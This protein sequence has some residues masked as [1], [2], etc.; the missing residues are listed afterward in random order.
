MKILWVNCNFL[1]PTT[2]GGQIRTLE[3]LK[4]LHRD[5]EVHYVAFL[6]PSHPQA[7]EMAREYSTKAYPVEFEGFEKRSWRFLSALALSPMASLPLAIGRWKSRAMRELVSRLRKTE[8]FDSVVLDFLVTPVNVTPD[9]K[10]TVLFQHNVEAMIWERHHG[11][12]ANPLKRVYLRL[13]R[14]RMRAFERKICHAVDH[15]ITVSEQDANQHRSRYGIESVSW[16]PT[17]VDLDYFAPPAAAA[18]Q[19]IDLMFL[20]SMDWMPNIDGVAWFAE[21][22]LPE[23]LTRRPGTKIAIVGRR[24]PAS[25]QDLAN[26]F[27]GVT[28]TGTVDDVRPYLWRSKVSIVP[29][30][31]GGGTRLKIYESVAARVPVVS[32]TIGAEGLDL[33]HPAQIRLADTPAAFVEE[34]LKLLAN[35]NEGSALSEESWRYVS[36]HYSW[37][38]VTQQFADILSR[39]A[40]TP[41]AGR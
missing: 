21:T 30:R 31:V 13:Q 34:C 11:L 25:I 14:D 2:K 9:L 17:G 35:P 1:H 40:I 37:D 7:A 39:Y 41:V 20:G 19:D 23:I 22:M 26:R 6:D 24:P 36:R 28:I 10:G 15:V 38:S 29:L 16:V 3:M 12:A 33:Q 32:T 18:A 27:P 8:D 5:H 4:R